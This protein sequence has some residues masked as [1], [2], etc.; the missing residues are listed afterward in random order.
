MS[1]PRFVCASSCQLIQNR[2]KPVDGSTTKHLPASNDSC[3]SVA[4]GEKETQLVDL[5]EG[6][7]IVSGGGQRTFLNVL[8][9]GIS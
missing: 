4:T 7:S 5:R 1:T 2:Q 6:N 3:S 8:V 9:L